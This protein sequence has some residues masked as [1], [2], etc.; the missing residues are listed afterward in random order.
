VKI[1]KNVETASDHQL[2]GGAMMKIIEYVILT[3]QLE[4]QLNFVGLM[5][6]F[7]HW[8]VPWTKYTYLKAQ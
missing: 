3:Q 6:H 4:L 8:D 1:T 7:K 5:K 2:V